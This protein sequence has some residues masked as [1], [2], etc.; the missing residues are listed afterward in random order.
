MGTAMSQQVLIATATLTIVG[1]G[2][3]VD[4]GTNSDQNKTE[5][6]VIKTQMLDDATLNDA[7]DPENQDAHDLRDLCLPWDLQ[8]EESKWNHYAG[9]ISVSDTPAVSAWGETD[10]SSA[11]AVTTEVSAANQWKAEPVIKVDDCPESYLASGDGTQC[12]PTADAI[13]T[14]ANPGEC[15]INYIPTANTA[16]CRLAIQPAYLLKGNPIFK[17]DFPSVRLSNGLLQEWIDL[18][19]DG[20]YEVSSLC[21]P[22]TSDVSSTD[23][24]Q[25]SADPTCRYRKDSVLIC[26]S[27]DHNWDQN[28]DSIRLYVDDALKLVINDADFNGH[29]EWIDIYQGGTLIL[30]E[31]D[32]DADGHVEVKKHFVD[33]KLS[34]INKDTNGDNEFDRWEFFEED[35]T[36]DKILIDTPDEN[37][38]FDGDW[39][40]QL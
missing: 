1:C 12:V 36:V 15:P 31:K 19:N 18:N 34:Q 38:E 10:D 22:K 28:G 14:I 33:G 25:S 7:V 29:F 30:S 8:A 4:E 32:L 17:R 6:K 9:T 5:H 39:D 27:N 26:K 40:T 35:G 13:K 11:A 23:N 21:I 37:G 2:P 3:K 16:Y 24:E 20:S